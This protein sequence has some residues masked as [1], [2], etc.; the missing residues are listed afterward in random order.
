MLDDS[1]ILGPIANFGSNQFRAAAVG[2]TALGSVSPAGTAYNMQTS[3][4][5]L[6]VLTGALTGTHKNAF[7]TTWKHS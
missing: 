2:G 3:K 4:G 6:Q 7:K 5:V 1:T